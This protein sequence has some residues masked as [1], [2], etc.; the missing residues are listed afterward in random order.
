MQI[1]KLEYVHFTSPV[2]SHSVQ[3]N[4]DIKMAGNKDKIQT[5]TEDVA[6]FPPPAPPV[7]QRRSTFA[8]WRGEWYLESH[9]CTCFLALS[10]SLLMLVQHQLSASPSS[11]EASENNMHGTSVRITG[12]TDFTKHHWLKIINTS[13]E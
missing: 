9:F 12:Q 5:N 11:T 4:P 10:A 3:Q 6:Q 7:H 1:F 8:S 13:Y 2:K